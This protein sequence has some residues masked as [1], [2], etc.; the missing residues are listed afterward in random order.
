MKDHFVLLFMHSFCT[1]AY[2]AIVD[3]E[4]AWHT[5]QPEHKKMENDYKQYIWLE[6]DY[7]QNDILYSLC[8]IMWMMVMAWPAFHTMLQISVD[9]NNNLV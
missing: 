7:K 3:N 8:S 1:L 6:N 5:T 2:F 9:S 4:N